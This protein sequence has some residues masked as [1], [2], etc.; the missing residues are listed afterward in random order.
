MQLF[1]DAFAAWGCLVRWLSPSL[2][3]LAWP[4]PNASISLT[5]ETLIGGALVTVGR[6]ALQT[7]AVALLFSL[8]HSAVQNRKSVKS[9][10]GSEKSAGACSSCSSGLAMSVQEPAFP[11]S[12]PSAGKKNYSCG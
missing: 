2:V 10:G 5:R 7:V 8:T 3:R 11:G 9:E 6:R 4:E 1:G 12:A